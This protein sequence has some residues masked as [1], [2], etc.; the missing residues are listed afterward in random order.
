MMIDALNDFCGYYEGIVLDASKPDTLRTL[1]N[2][3]GFGAH[4]FFL[5]CFD[6]IKI[7]VT[8]IN[9]CKFSMG[10]K[11]ANQEC[12]RILRRA[13]DECDQSSTD[14]K[15]GG[16]IESNCAQWRIDPNVNWE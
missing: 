6:I 16:T 8:V 12:G 11:G 10:G 2:E 13:I 1:T 15:Q 4:C 7:S 3:P 9:G 14:F 5:G